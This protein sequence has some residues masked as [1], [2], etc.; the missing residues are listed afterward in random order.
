MQFVFQPLTWGF[1]LVLVPL[2]AHLINLLRHRR[3]QWAAMEFLLESYRK[4]RRWVW[5]KQLLLLLSRMAIMAVLVAMLAQWVTGAKWLSIFGQTVTHH[6]ILLDDSLSMADSV[7]GVTAYQA[8]LRA[9]ASILA[10]A[11]DDQGSQQVTV[12]RYSRALSQ[13]SA[14]TIDSV[15]DL[16]ARSIPGD[17]AP[18]L[19][20]LNRSAPV[21]LAVSPIAAVETIVPLI[22]EASNEQ[23]LLYLISD[24]RERD[25]RQSQSIRSALE[26]LKSK[27][28]INLVDC[29]PTPHENLSIV[30]MRPDQEVLAA[31]VPVMMRLDVHNP[32]STPARNVSISIKSFENLPSDTQPR[33]DRFASGKEANLPPLVLD[34]VPPGET[35]SRRFQ[36]IFS[37]PGSQ[38]VQAILPD[39]ALLE[40][41]SFA[42]ALDVVE[43][44][45][46]LLIDGSE[47]RRGAFYLNATLNPGG[48]T[49]TGWR[50]QTEGPA[51]LRDTSPEI[52]KSFAAVVLMN[53]NA[54]D[55]R[56]I[57]NLETYASQGGGITIALGGNLTQ[58]DID[59]MNRDWHRRGQGLLPLAVESLAELPTTAASGESPDMTATSHPIFGPLLG[60]GNSPFQWVRVF[61]YVKLAVPSATPSPAAVSASQTIM[62]LRDGSPLMIDHPFGEGRIVVFCSAIDPSWTTWPQD[63]TFVVGMLKTMGYLASFRAP[64]TSSLIGVP[65]ESTFSSREQLPEAEIVLP[66]LGRNALRQTMTLIAAPQTEPML[67]LRIAP[68][69][70]TRSETELNALLSPG[71]TE[72]WST[73]LSGERRVKNYARNAPPQEGELKKIAASELLAGLRPLEAKYRVADSLSSGTALAGLSNR[74]GLLLLLLVL[75]LLVEQFLAWSASYHLPLAKA[76]KGAA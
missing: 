24:F 10:G 31:G 5:M 63:P 69:P 71:V 11:A 9:I 28:E 65:I 42:A 36:A 45:S 3:T 44:Q 17:P 52:L 25:W 15:A 13:S 55:Q 4:H 76:V 18:L 35:V 43:G 22:R 29:V 72:V 41:N 64:E 70:S 33:A 12:L 48:M 56:A 26:P 21:G 14:P 49:R 58:A 54:L 73:L 2:I 23:S 6:Y 37:H 20:T 19:E 32:G 67:N 66:S 1:L 60:S 51:F 57:T 62:K 34:V 75:L 74:Q 16:L 47:N 8:G 61:R 40:D 38:V 39:D 50:S 68:D 53:V 7:Q 46:L 30:A 59:R 27:A